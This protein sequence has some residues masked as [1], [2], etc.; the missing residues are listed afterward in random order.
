MNEPKTQVQLCADCLP[1]AS[2][3]LG[4]VASADGL[5]SICDGCHQM[6][7]IIAIGTPSRTML[8][9]KGSRL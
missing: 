2:H 3:K 7:A 9:V 4:G 5:V 6:R 8:S 1:N